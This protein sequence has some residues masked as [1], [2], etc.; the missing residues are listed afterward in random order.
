MKLTI[1]SCVNTGRTSAKGDA[2]YSVIANDG[3]MDCKGSSFSDLSQFIEKEIEIERKD[4]KEY[5]GEMQYY[6]ILPKPAG[7][8]GGKS[9]FPAKDWTFAKRQVALEC[10]TNWSIAQ[11]N[12]GITVKTTDIEA[13]ATSLFTW[14]NQK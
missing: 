12:K 4:G 9:N 7:Q 3:L 13:I 10:A 8:Q 14:L 5:Q 6:F 1:V 2:I 11:L